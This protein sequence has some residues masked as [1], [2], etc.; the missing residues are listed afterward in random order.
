MWCILEQV[1]KNHK[2]KMQMKGMKK[3]VN[4]SRVSPHAILA[5]LQ[6]ETSDMS[7]TK[8]E[9]KKIT[10]RDKTGSTVR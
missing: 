5:S 1:E 2:R 6:M 9:P 10:I 3:M 4:E 8:K 7:Y